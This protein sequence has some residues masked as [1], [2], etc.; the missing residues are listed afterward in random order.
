MQSLTAFLDNL[1][2]S[3]FHIEY[4]LLRL[5]YA[6]DACV[7]KRPYKFVIFCVSGAWRAVVFATVVALSVLFA[8]VSGT[9]RADD[10]RLRPE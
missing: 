5:K 9:W 4:N 6:D 7:T 1:F 8:A 10:F 2:G 3:D